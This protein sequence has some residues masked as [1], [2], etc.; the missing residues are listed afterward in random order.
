MGLK[1]FSSDSPKNSA[2]RNTKTSER[3]SATE[4]IVGNSD[5]DLKAVGMIVCGKVEIDQT[6]RPIARCDL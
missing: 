2:E 4:W 3:L 1:G 5:C 6:V